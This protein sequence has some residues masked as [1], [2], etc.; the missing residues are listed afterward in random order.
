MNKFLETKIKQKAQWVNRRYPELLLL[1]LIQEG[2]ELVAKL[3]KNKG[4]DIS[5]PYLLKA[6]SFHFSNL[7]RSTNIRRN[8]KL[9]T[10]SSLTDHEDLLAEEEFTKLENK[11]DNEKFIRTIKNKNLLQILSDLMTGHNLQEIANRRNTS[12]R[13]IYRSLAVIRRLREEWANE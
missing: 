1:D 3:Q 4:K 12:I 11:I 8:I 2:H 5:I 7:M 10:L 6:L 9:F 13:T